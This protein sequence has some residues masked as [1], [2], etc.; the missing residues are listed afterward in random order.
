MGKRQHLDARRE[1]AVE[2]VSEQVSVQVPP[3]NRSKQGLLE[4]LESIG[5]GM[6]VVV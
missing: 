3:F 1:A 5:R 2:A 4:R 6:G